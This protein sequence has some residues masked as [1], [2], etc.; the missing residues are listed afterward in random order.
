MNRGT[1]IFHP[2]YKFEDGVVAN[3]LFIIL[4]NAP[5]RGDVLL[6]AKTTSQRKS[7]DAKEG[8]NHR[9]LEFFI[10]EGRTSFRQDTWVILNPIYPVPLAEMA[11]RVMMKQCF[12]KDVLN[13]QMMNAI[14]NCALQSDDIEG[15]WVKLLKK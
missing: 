15:R 13:E 6:L 8:C 10:P 1:V 7:R 4:N 3:K 9:R 14:R 11:K 12:V 5:D 2:D